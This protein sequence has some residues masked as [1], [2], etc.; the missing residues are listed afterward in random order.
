MSRKSRYWKS[1]NISKNEQNYP[2]W[3]L[4]NM[5]YNSTSCFSFVITLK[6]GWSSQVQKVRFPIKSLPFQWR[7]FLPLLIHSLKRLIKKKLLA[8][9]SRSPE[10][11]LVFCSSIKFHHKKRNIFIFCLPENKK[12]LKEGNHYQEYKCQYQI[13]LFFKSFFLV[14][15]NT[16]HRYKILRWKLS[17]EEKTNLYFILWGN[18]FK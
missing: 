12:Y 17:G 8:I 14:F 11:I 16:F 5:F 4:R 18:S 10:A 15:F 7:M 3:K 1:Y 13:R 9:K 2:K 6:I